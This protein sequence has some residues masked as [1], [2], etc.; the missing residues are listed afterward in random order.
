M[1][2]FE[3]VVTRPDETLAALYNF[4][5]VEM[6]PDATDVKVVSQGFRA[7]ER[8]LDAGAADRWRQHIG[9]FEKRWL[10]LVLRRPMRL[11][12]YRS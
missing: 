12:D 9:G 7:G 5:D 3:D 1:V 6:P 10:E 4:L 2:R 11:V 8:G